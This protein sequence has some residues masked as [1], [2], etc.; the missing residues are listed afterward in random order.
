[1]KE[2]RPLSSIP[3][4]LSTRLVSWFSAGV[5]A[6]GDL[7][8]PWECPICEGD[9]SGEGAPFCPDCRTELLEAADEACPR[10]ASPVGP[11]AVHAAGCGQ[12]KGRS[13]GFDAAVAL[14]PYQGPIRDLCL[15]LKHENNAWIAP[16]LADVLIEA[17]PFLR[18]E[19]KSRL[20]PPLVVPIPLHWRRRWT[21]GYNQAEE[22][23]RGLARGLDL[24]RCHALRRVKATAISARLGKA[25]RA[26]SLRGAFRVRAGRNAR[27][28]GRSVFL[29]DDILT[30]GATCAAAAR[31]LKKAGAARVIAVVIARA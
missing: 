12:C 4:G 13:L 27:L 23:A 26:R 9:G 2:P 10:C 22:L 5:E 15:R 31:A 11:W 30:T 17:R 20:E 29:V 28:K 18:N 16:W 21:R 7:V 25:E 1:M 8:L 14:G 6:L 19:A 3:S 24:P